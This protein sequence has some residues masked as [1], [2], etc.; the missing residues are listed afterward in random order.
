MGLA[1][2][3]VLGKISGLLEVGLPLDGPL[4]ISYKQWSLPRI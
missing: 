3:A 4:F 2:Q 1:P